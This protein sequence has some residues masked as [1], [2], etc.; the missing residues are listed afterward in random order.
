VAGGEQETYEC[1]VLM[2]GSGCAGLSATIQMPAQLAS[3]LGEMK[4]E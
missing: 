3:A 2:V 4:C 1:D